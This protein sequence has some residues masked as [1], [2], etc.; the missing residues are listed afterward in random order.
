M[1]LGSCIHLDECSPKLPSILSL[2]LLFTVHWLSKFCH[3]FAFWSFSQRLWGQELWNFGHANI[4]MS[5]AQSYHQYWALTYFL[6]FTDFLN[7][8]MILRFGHFLRDYEG[9]SYETSVMQTSGWV[10]LKATINTE[11]WPTF[12][13]SLTF[14]ILSWFCVLVIFSETMR[15]RAMKLRSCK[16]LDECSSKLPSILSLDLL[17]TVHWLSKVCHDFAFWS[18]SQRLWGQEL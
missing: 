10:Q 13:G 12:Y 4:L 2:D 18:F 17:F 5:A 3:D 14:Q 16:H 8:V 11:P 7:F 1:Q 6:R 9:K 15:A